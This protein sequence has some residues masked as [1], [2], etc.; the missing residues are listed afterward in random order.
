MKLCVSLN[1]GAKVTPIS[2]K[3][4]LRLNIKKS[5]HRSQFN[6]VFICK[7][8]MRYVM[9]IENYLPKQRQWTKEP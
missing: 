2:R 4:K 5:I 9:Y 6:T 8:C 3:K 7:D 1:N